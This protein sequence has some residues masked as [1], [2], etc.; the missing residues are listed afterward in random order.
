MSTTIERTERTERTGRFL[1]AALAALAA[2]FGLAAAVTLALEPS[3]SVAVFAP[4]SASLS[5]TVHADARLIDARSG[6]VVIRGE[7]KG[8]VRRLY[9]GG[10]WLVLP[11]F[12]G[13][14]RGGGEPRAGG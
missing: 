11:A 5:A 14:C 4:L 3:T 6:F 1:G 9:A 10:A 13:G 12:T 7:H 2:W 8:F